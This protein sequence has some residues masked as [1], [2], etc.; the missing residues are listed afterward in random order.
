MGDFD[1]RARLPRYATGASSSRFPTQ[2]TR[3][4]TAKPG[5]LMGSSGL[6]VVGA[7]A[8][9]MCCLSTPNSGQAERF[10]IGFFPLFAL[11]VMGPVNMVGFVTGVLGV[12]FTQQRQSSG[13]WVS[14][15]MQPPTWRS[16]PA[17]LSSS[18]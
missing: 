1:G 2:E 9:A 16:L 11:V 12:A 10:V 6:V 8:F 15:S 3:R 4:K 17:C 14:S 13:G 7:T 5:I 18:R